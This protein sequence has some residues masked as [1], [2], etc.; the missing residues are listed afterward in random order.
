VTA[1]SIVTID[2]ARRMIHW[3]ARRQRLSVSALV[4]TTAGISD[5]L[6]SFS[7][8]DEGARGRTKDVNLGLLLQL[9]AA[10]EHRLVSRPVGG[11]HPMLRGPDMVPLRITGAD[12]ELLKIQIEKL[13]DVAVLANTLAAINNMTVTALSKK[14]GISQTITTFVSGSSRSTDL[15][16]RPLIELNLAGG[17]EFA[18]EPLFANRRE[19]R[20]ASVTA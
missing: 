3:V 5:S 16:L 7:N 13:G 14:A 6:V 18:V 9:L 15:R 4:D 12:G 11:Q 19:A 17:F 2:D 20:R 8:L 10:H 1:F